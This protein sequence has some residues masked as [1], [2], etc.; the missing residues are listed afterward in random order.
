[1]SR[2]MQ[3]RHEIKHEITQADILLLRSKLSVIAAADSHSVN[4]CYTIRSLYFDNIY[5]KALMEKVNGLNARE[6]YRI[7]YYNGDTTFIKLEKKSKLNGLTCKE[8]TFVTANEVNLL[9]RGDFKWMRESER[10]LVKELY[11]KMMNQGLRP[12]TIVDYTREAYTYAAGNV[13]ITMDYD[14]RTG[15]Y[16]MDFLNPD[17]LMLPIM[18]DVRILEVKWDSFLPDTIRNVIQLENRRA[19]AF[20]K[21]AACR[22]Y[23]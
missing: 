1:M 10:P 13:R 19:G 23:G 4:G 8:C 9:L 5:D 16:G 21:Y 14:I 7:R 20:S 12:K 3:Y 17:C 18:D 15:M 11:L 2:H 6:K 22:I